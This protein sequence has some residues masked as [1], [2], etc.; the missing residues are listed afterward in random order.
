MNAQRN[1]CPPLGP[2]HVDE[3]R[4]PCLLAVQ[5]GSQC[6]LPRC[7]P[8]ADPKSIA[9]IGSRRR[10]E[11]YALQSFALRPIDMPCRI[12]LIFYQNDGKTHDYG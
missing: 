11:R 7:T 2:A 9:W 6:F 1:S 5:P 12:D 8:S 4:L 10:T 3:K